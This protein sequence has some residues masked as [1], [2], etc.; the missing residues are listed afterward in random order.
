MPLV[1]R[2][3]SYSKARRRRRLCEGVR[4]EEREEVGADDQDEEVSAEEIMQGSEG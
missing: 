4:A 2:S 1:I 3:G